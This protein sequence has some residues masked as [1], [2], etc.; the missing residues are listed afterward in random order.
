M[1]EK[2]EI[3]T[4]ERPWG[5]FT[6]LW[7]D[8]GYKVK[9]IVVNPGHRLSLQSHNHRYEHWVIV[10][11][12]AIAQVGSEKI[13]LTENQ[14]IFIPVQAKHRVENP[15]PDVLIFTETQYGDYLGEDDITRFEDDYN[16]VK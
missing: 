5:K 10:K 6:N 9:R 2:I 3:Y 4:E 13:E 14:H 16:R 7:E 15:G 1:K 11:G 12:K 8:E